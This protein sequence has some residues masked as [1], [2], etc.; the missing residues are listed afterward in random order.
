MLSV[1]ES[2]VPSI[3]MISLIESVYTLSIVEENHSLPSRNAPQDNPENRVK[4]SDLID[5]WNNINENTNT[6]DYGLKIGQYFDYKNR[7]LLASLLTQCEDLKD[8]LENFILHLPWMN[9]SEKW[10]LEY[11]GEYVDLYY[12]LD[13]NKGYPLSAI[14]R[15]MCAII[16]WG[17]KLSGTDF[18]IHSV[19]FQHEKPDYYQEYVSAFCDDINFSSSHNHIRIKRCFLEKKIPTHNPYIKSFLINKFLDIEVNAN[20]AKNSKKIT[21]KKPVIE[22]ITGLLPENRAT[23]DIVC[24]KLSVSRQTLYRYLKKE[25]TSFKEILNEVRR[26]KSI[27]LLKNRQL[28][29]IEISEYLGYKDVSSFYNAFNNWYSMSISQYRKNLKPDN[30]IYIN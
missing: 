29:I 19:S 7:G 22:L 25:N 28:N 5:L 11:N 26:E 14:E 18:E 12:S 10:A 15:S 3:S 13:L 9:N 8:A 24:K 4:E 23:I 2:T 21:Y 6:P 30:V 27:E 16:T 17:K 1:Y 20:A